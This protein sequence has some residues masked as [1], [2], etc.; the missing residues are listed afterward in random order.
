[1]WLDA[2]LKRAGN[3][4]G[5]GRASFSSSMAGQGCILC[6]EPSSFAVDGGFTD[7]GLG[8]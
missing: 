6:D 7:G 1:M 3:K 5:P 2:I 8:Y 4:T